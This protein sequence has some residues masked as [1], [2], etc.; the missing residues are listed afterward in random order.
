MPCGGGCGA[1]SYSP[2]L[3]RRGGPAP[4]GHY[5]GDGV[6]TL[7]AY[8]PGGHLQDTDVLGRVHDVPMR[9]WVDGVAEYSASRRLC[10]LGRCPPFRVY[11]HLKLVQMTTA[12]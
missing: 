2:R 1:P 6:D 8:V 4:V 9:F 5:L 7:V 10:P 11:V 12:F 3:T